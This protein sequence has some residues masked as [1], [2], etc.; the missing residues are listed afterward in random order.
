[1]SVSVVKI[2]SF[3]VDDAYLS[4]SSEQAE[5]KGILTIP[6]KSDPDLCM[7]LDGWDE[8]TSIPAVLNGKQLLLYK[9]HYDRQADAWVMRVA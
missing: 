6:C 1:M 3:E 7:Q 5:G 4:T 2:G 9:Q 8:H